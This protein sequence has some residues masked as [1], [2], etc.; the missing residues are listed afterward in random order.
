[1]L[2]WATFLKS[3]YGVLETVNAPYYAECFEMKT[4]WSKLLT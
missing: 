4:F 3:K 1:M 2:F